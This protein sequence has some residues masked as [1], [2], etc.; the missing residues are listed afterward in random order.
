MHLLRPPHSPGALRLAN[1]LATALLAAPAQAADMP[2][3]IAWTAAQIEA[4]G[5][6]VHQLGAGASQAGAGLV[7][8][9][10][11]ELPPQATE[12][13]SSPLA[14]VVQQVLV[15]PGQRVRAGEVVARLTSPELLVW[16]RELLQAQ[17]QA[18]LTA[19]RLARDEQLYAEGIIPGLRLQDSRA[20]SEQAQL[21]LQERRQALQALGLAGGVLQAQLA[22][23]AAA[24]GTVLELSALPGQRLDAGMPVARIA[25]SGQL[26][27]VLQATPEQ[28]GRL[29][30]GDTLSIAGCTN[31]ARLT[32]IT[33]QVNSANQSVQLRADF[34]AAEDCLRL[35]QF[36]EATVQGAPAKGDASTLSVPAQ[37]VVRQAGKAYV[38]VRSNQGFLPTAVELGPQAN[39]AWQVRSGLKAGDEVAISGTAAL[40]GA[41]LGLGGEGK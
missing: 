16:Q 29:R 31:P 6:H 27:L 19:S 8:Q 7:L 12:L 23:R 38:F 20:A 9:G 34:T 37:A 36:V 10:Q 25:R 3:T 1:L 39:G 33:P 17:S 5:V 28:A 14:G 40:K 13:L 35:Q 21:A 18:R 4:A 32:A 2:A 26:A 15:A 41:W 22:L 24:T 30:V 11:V